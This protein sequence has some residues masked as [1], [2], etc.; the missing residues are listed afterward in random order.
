MH[1]CAAV[2]R[3]IQLRC[4]GAAGNGNLLELSIE[5]SRARATVGEISD[6]MEQVFS[7]HRATIRT[8]AGVYGGAYEGDESYDQIRHEVDEFLQRC[9]LHHHHARSLRANNRFM[10]VPK[11]AGRA[12][13]TP[14]KV[15]CSSR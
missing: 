14:P 1:D 7:R 3:T 4:D 5:A 15:S 11:S 8:I 6:A 10:I 13:D 9:G 12:R 2:E